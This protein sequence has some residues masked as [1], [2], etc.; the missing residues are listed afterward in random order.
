MKDVVKT[1]MLSKAW[2]GIW[3]TV[4]SLEFK[5]GE[6]EVNSFLPFKG[7]MRQILNAYDKGKPIFKLCVQFDYFN[8]IRN[9]GKEEV[10]AYFDSCLQFAT[11]HKAQEVHVI[12]HVNEPDSEMD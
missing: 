12:L 7:F 11:D 10:V 1:E 4:T 9:E 2:K 8:A 6:D 3:K 5:L